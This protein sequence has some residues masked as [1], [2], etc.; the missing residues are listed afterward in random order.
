MFKLISI[1]FRRQLPVANFDKSFFQDG[2]F[3]ATEVSYSFYYTLLRFKVNL[4]LSTNQL[5][6]FLSGK[7]MKISFPGSLRSIF[8]TVFDD[9]T[10][11]S[12]AVELISELPSQD[13]HVLPKPSCPKPDRHTCWLEWIR[14]FA[15]RG[16]TWERKYDVYNE[17]FVHDGLNA[18]TWNPNPCSRLLPFFCDSPF[19]TSIYYRLCLC[20]SP[21]FAPVHK[22]LFIKRVQ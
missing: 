14:F 11:R 10:E 22:M 19:R 21:Q 7:K 6:T 9:A 20:N 4:P 15:E 8:V 5:E 1:S 18:T 2:S 17:Y 3:R 16:C 13:W 12:R